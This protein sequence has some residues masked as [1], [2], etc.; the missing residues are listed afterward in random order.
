MMKECGIKEDVCAYV[1]KLRGAD[2]RLNTDLG[3]IKEKVKLLTHYDNLKGSILQLIKDGVYD[4]KEDV[5]MESLSKFLKPDP[6][7]PVDLEKIDEPEVQ[8]AAKTAKAKGRRR[9]TDGAA[10]IIEPA[11]GYVA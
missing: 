8:P 4:L 7:I 6:K 2:Y 1:H 11:A 9:R 10:A 3:G 5:P